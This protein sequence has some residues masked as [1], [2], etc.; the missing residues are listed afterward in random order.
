MTDKFCKQRMPHRPLLPW[1]YHKAGSAAHRR[2][3]LGYLGFRQ[4]KTVGREKK[5][6]FQGVSVA[7]GKRGYAGGAGAGVL[8][9]VAF[10]LFFTRIKWVSERV[11]K[12]LFNQPFPNEAVI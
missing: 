5:I 10:Y 11:S 12:M 8:S 1:Q 3:A 9:G 4:V 6:C 7:C 2:G